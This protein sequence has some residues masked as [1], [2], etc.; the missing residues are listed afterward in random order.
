MLFFMQLQLLEF[1]T[2]IDYQNKYN[3]VN[4]SHRPINMLKL[5]CKSKVALKKI[6]AS[7]TIFK[8]SLCICSNYNSK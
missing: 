2:K 7:F 4:K 8:V 5:S 6:Q 3:L 1:S